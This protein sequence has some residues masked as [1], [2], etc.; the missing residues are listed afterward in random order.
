MLGKENGEYMSKY[1]YGL[2]GWETYK[3][4]ENIH[5]ACQSRTIEPFAMMLCTSKNVM[6]VNQVQQ[7]RPA[8]PISP[9]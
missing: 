1:L 6:D 3:R 4:F 9:K 8:W 2:F 7:V 5:G